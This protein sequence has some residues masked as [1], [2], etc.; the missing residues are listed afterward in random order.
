MKIKLVSYFVDGGNQKYLKLSKLCEEVNK[1]YCNLYNYDIQFDYYDKQKIINHYGTETKY[2]LIDYKVPF[3]SEQLNKQDCDYL[4]FV[5]A[6]AA[7]NKPTIKIEDLIDNQHE[8]FLSRGNE[9]VL[10]INCIVNIANKLNQI[11]QRE[12]TENY[13]TKNYYD[14]TIMKQYDLYKDFERLSIGYV[15]WNEGFC[16]IKNTPNMRK[17]FEQ[18]TE[19]QK[20]FFI[21]TDP[22]SGMT[23]D[24]RA[25]IFML[26]QKR[27]KDLYT[28]LPEF[29]QGGLANSYQ[30]HFDIQKTFVLHNYGQALNLDQKIECVQ[31]LKHNKWWNKVLNNK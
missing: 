3:M 11:F 26:C 12:R 16:V 9:K 5:D 1:R 20:R 19:V 24:G 18:C 30:T 17:Y 21:D 28:F 4:V 8:L 6:D 10:Q 7:I 29:A 13:L 14:Q 23:Q 27:Y 2:C 22:E 15:L 25:M 31:S